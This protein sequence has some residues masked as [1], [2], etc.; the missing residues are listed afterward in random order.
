MWINNGQIIEYAEWFP[1]QPS[2][3]NSLGQDENCLTIN[4]SDKFKWND[5]NCDIE[6]TIERWP[7]I[8][9]KL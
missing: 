1:G 4:Y 9:Q 6:N 5:V 7:A 3:L 8:C 2:N